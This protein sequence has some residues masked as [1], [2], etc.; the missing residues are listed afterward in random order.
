[1][2][3]TLEGPLSEVLLYSVGD[4]APPTVG[5]RGGGGGGG[6]RF[7]PSLSTTADPHAGGH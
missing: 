3:Q 4:V 1:M 2:S 6:E 7:P 5:A